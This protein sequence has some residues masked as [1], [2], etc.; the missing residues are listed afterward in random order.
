MSRTLI[1][2][3]EVVDGSKA[4]RR[5]AD[6]LI[7]GAQIEA[8]LPDI[9]ETDTD[10][11]IDAKGMVVV[12]GFVDIH[13]HGDLVVAEPPARQRE[14]QEGRLAQG[15]TTE[16]VGN[17][18]LGVFPC[19]PESLPALRAVVGWMTPPLAASWP[20]GRWSNLR[21]Y[22]DWVEANSIWN[23]VGALQPHGPLRISA[24]GLERS[25]PTS[26]TIAAM[27]RDL[28]EALEAG[29]YGL[30]TGLIYPP[31]IYTEPEEIVMLSRL[32]KRASGAPGF[33]ASHIRG[34]SETLLP[35]VNELLDLGRSADVRVQ[36][37]HNE[38]VGKAHWPKIEQVLAIEERARKSGVQ[39]TYDMF[40]YTA[41]ATMMLAIYPPWALE[42]GA[43]RF[44]E[45]LANPE[46]R[47]RIRVAI[48]TTE[49]TWPPWTE[50]GWPHNLVRAVGWNNVTIGSCPSVRNRRYEGMSVTELGKA[51]GKTAFDAIADLMIDEKGLVSQI[52]HEISGDEG[53][54][55]GIDM[56]LSHP[57]GA[58]CT[59][60]NDFGK[61]NPHPAAFGT[62]P[63]IL[64]HYVRDRRLLTLEEAVWK[65]TGYPASL[66]GLSDRGLLR[67][68][69]FADVVVFDPATVDSSATF[70]EPR[71]R[72]CGI[73]WVLVNGTPLIADGKGVTP[74]QPP[75]RVLR[76][77]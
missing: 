45:R 13:S 63:R 58:V 4:P 20:E 29:A 15:I 73:A 51:T 21:S 57:A 30:S 74:E 40:P 10:R 9:P 22:F 18:G 12:P 44:V 68:G 70:D 67:K 31:G 8:I 37:S 69:S 55:E 33:V 16:I 36:H 7:S 47:E 11:V 75:G 17:C 54:E 38:A 59:D 39:V 61:G 49:P 19:T 41:A 71:H 72:A 64:G 43:A 48:D 56:L 66:L 2:G 34:S 24:A 62:C 26:G 77:R 46:T 35:A 1:R 28:E 25:G 52:I 65:M 50:D 14:L 76:R 5:R 3:G 42:G 60:A 27:S 32:V 6:V 53:N 23:N